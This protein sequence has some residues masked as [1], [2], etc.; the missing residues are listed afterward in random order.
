MVLPID[1]ENSATLVFEAEQAWKLFG[2]IDYVFLNGGMAVRDLIDD[3]GMDMIHKVMN[4]NFYGN[5]EIT[6][7][8]LP[9]M[10]KKGR[11][12]F[13]VTSSLC[14][15]FGVP[16]LGAYSASKHALH[17]FFESLRAEN[18]NNGIQVTIIT[19]GL[20]NTSITLNALNGNGSVYG[21]MQE[22][23][24]TG[25]SANDCARRIIRAVSKGKSEVLIG[26][27]EIIGVFINRFFPRLLRLVITRHP[28]QKLRNLGFL[29]SNKTK[30]LQV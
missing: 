18:Q 3:T 13:I 11:G 20:V 28:V 5:V 27:P 12:C 17:G 22:S 23:I 10:K 4:I 16:K 14:G 1:L 15:K 29:P 7:A 21:K 9:W 24:A 19:A 2:R 8:L 6:K 30:L 25:I 26:G